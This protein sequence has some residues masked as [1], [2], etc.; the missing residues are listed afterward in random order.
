M[1][2]YIKREA[3]LRAVQGQRSPCRSPAQNRMLDC[4]KAAVIRISA[5]DV[6]P[7]EALERLRD[8]LCAQ[9]LITMEGLRKLNTLIWKYTTV[10][11]GGADHEAD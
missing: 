10:H 8:E 3:V 6:A 1:D 4:L 11:D 7:I 9:D 5:A 2:E